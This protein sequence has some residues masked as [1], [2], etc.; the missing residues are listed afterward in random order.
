MDTK[1]PKIRDRPQAYFL[2]AIRYYGFSPHWRVFREAGF[3]R[4]TIRKKPP[5]DKHIYTLSLNFGRLKFPFT[6]ED[7]SR[8]WLLLATAFIKEMLFPK[9]TISII[10]RL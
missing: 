10:A 8:R 9:G 4:I 7:P 2:S 1:E 6:L 3:L 5:T